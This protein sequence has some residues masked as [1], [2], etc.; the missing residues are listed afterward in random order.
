MRPA[1]EIRQALLGAARQLATPDRGPTLQELAAAARVGY[2]A[3]MYTVKNLTRAGELQVV[4]TRRVEYRNRPV[5][6]YVAPV[7]E[8]DAVA[9]RPFVDLGSILQ[10]WAA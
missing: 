7:V 6:E 3:A 4:R 10:T 8:S 2:E 5:A 9:S 1:G